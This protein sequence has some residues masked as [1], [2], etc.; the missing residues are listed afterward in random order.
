M[1]FASP[2]LCVEIVL[3]MLLDTLLPPTAA[4]QHGSSMGFNESKVALYYLRSGH[5]E[6][7]HFCARMNAEV[8]KGKNYSVAVMARYQYIN[9]D[10]PD[11]DFAGTGYTPQEL[12]INGG[13]HVYQVGI[14]S[15][16]T[17]HLWGKPL[18]AFAMLRTD[19]S[20]HGFGRIDAMGAAM[21]MLTATRET[22]F[23]VGPVLLVNTASKWPIF[24]MFIYRRQFSRELALGLFGGICTL[25][26]TPT[27]A[28]CLSVGFDVD[29]RTFY[30]SPNTDDLPDVCRYTK[31]LFRPMAR[32]RRRLTKQ[33]TA[34]VECG[35]ELKMSSKV[36][37]RSGTRDYLETDS[38]ASAFGLVTISSTL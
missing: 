21:L 24:P 17:S 1:F 12:N 6:T 15:M 19:F 16:V 30:F 32:Y 37:G 13:H 14:N 3:I 11:E 20:K 22:Q 34:E 28:D 9:T 8:M 7:D 36:Y 23:G 18:M 31:T 2:C 33:I 38:P 5:D 26:Y 10:I 25:D 27:R 29:A 4:A 35:V